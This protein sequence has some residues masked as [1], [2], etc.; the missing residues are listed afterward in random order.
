M[1]AC[2]KVR[3]PHIKGLGTRVSLWKLDISLKIA[4]VAKE[5]CDAK[6]SGARR[7]LFKDVNFEKSYFLENTT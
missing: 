1:L 3:Q 7:L 2:S 5:R 6:T 4:L